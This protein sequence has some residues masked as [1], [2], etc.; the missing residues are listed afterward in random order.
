VQHLSQ[1]VVAS[2]STHQHV[3]VQILI[4][5]KGSPRVRIFLSTTSKIH[6]KGCSDCDWASCIDIKRSITG[7]ATYIGDSLI[8][9]KS[10][11]QVTVSR[12]SSK[13]EYKALASVIC[14]L[15]W[16]TYLLEDFKVDFQQSATL[17]CDNKSALRIAVNP[18]F[19][20]RTKHIEIDCHIVREKVLS[21][22]VKLLPIP[23]TNQL[24]D[25]YTKVLMP[26]AFKFLHFKLGM[27]VSLVGL[28]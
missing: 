18:M 8:S 22:L 7:Y 23:S 21:G 19:H 3:V 6:L 15:Q 16:L 4:Y 11:K 26:G 28:N 24:D 27:K 17:Y 9:W 2:T 14:E 20:E 10:K 13:A 5:I 12:C 1:F 25:V